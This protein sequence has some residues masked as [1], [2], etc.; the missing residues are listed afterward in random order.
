VAVFFRMCFGGFGPMMRGMFMMPTSGMRMMRGLLVI[1]GLMVFGGFFMMLRR[2]LM[3]FRRVLVM[4]GCFR[5]HGTP[6]W[7]GCCQKT[8]AYSPPFSS[9]AIRL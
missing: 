1:P 3:M 7:K 2:V 9:V 6:P 4:L 8:S 5:G